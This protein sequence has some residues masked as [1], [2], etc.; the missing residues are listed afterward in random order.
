MNCSLSRHLQ[1]RRQVFWD[2]KISPVQFAWPFVDVRAF[3]YH[4]WY[5]S[6]P[7]NHSLLVRHRWLYHLL[8]WRQALSTRTCQFC[9]HRCWRK[10]KKHVWRCIFNAVLTFITSDVA[11]LPSSSIIFLAWARLFSRDMPALEPCL[12]IV[13]SA[14]ARA[15]ISLIRSNCRIHISQL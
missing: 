7:Q 2:I 13:S 3:P 15:K 14:M 12:F 6:S 4:G 1:Q 5:S 10:K 8:P 11:Y 9:R